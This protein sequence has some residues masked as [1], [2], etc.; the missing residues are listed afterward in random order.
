MESIHHQENHQEH[1][2]GNLQSTEVQFAHTKDCT[3]N[4]CKAPEVSD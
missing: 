1:E 2:H 4:Q 3:L